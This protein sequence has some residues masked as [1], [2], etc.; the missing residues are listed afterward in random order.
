M[1]KCEINKLFL[2]HDFLFEILKSIITFGDLKI[3]K[4]VVTFCPQILHQQF[5]AN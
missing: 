2:L 1:E 3:A 5:K 4:I